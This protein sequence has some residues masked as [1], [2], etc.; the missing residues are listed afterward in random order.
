MNQPM[1]YDPI[2]D[3]LPTPSRSGKLQL[4]LA[5]GGFLLL[6]V[7]LTLG[8]IW[9]D[10]LKQEVQVNSALPDPEVTG[11]QSSSGS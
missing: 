6:L 11:I 4:S 1:P 7:C 5:L 10:S 2:Y 3:E 8:F 9:L